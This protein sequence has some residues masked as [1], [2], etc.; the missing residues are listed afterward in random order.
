MPRLPEGTRLYKARMA[1][2]KQAEFERCIANLFIKNMDNDP[3]YDIS[4]IQSYLKLDRKGMCLEV[5]E[6]KGED[7]SLVGVKSIGFGHNR[8]LYIVTVPKGPL[9]VIMATYG[10]VARRLVV[11]KDS[12]REDIEGLFELMVM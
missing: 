9:K 4:S 12:E 6:L 7:Y 2:R 5:D 8:H 3:R 11:L 10:D 1:Q